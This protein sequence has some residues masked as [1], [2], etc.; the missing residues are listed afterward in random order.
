MSAAAVNIQESSSSSSSSVNV[1][2]VP[3]SETITSCFPPYQP[4][5]HDLE[6]HPSSYESICWG[7]GLRLILPSNASVFKC[8]W[9]GAITNQHHR[10]HQHK[11]VRW[12]RLRDRSFVALLLIFML[13]LICGGV[14]AVYPVLFSKGYFCGFFHCMLAF[15]LGVSTLSMFS[16]AAFSD[17]GTPPSIVW[18]SYPAVRKDEL[19]DYTF[20]HYCSQPKSPRAHHCST[21]GMCVLDMDHHCPFIGNCVG[22]ANHRH[23][24]SFL[25]VAVI[26]VTYAALM[27]AYT[28]LHISPSLGETTV[29]QMQMHRVG[30]NIAV[31]GI[32][33]DVV[34]AF[35]TSAMFFSTR[36]LI[37]LYLFVSSISVWIGLTVLLWQ[38]LY[39][40]YEGRTYLS[41]LSS[42]VEPQRDCRNLYLFFGCPYI[43]SWYLRACCSFKKIHRK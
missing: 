12:R 27:C 29:D 2:G 30:N 9:C 37:L 42:Q 7:C 24:V 35:M 36:G 6:Q 3:S 1:N 28:I 22:A 4:H 43:C 33:K 8:G 40:I 5:S 21:C 31:M 20:C 19:R 10:K 32:L 25:I 11:L 39:F 38:Q 13:F 26:S 34:I 41:S 14:W 16:L 23:F 15:I 18:G 17:P